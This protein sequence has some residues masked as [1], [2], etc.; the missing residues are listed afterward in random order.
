MRPCAT[1]LRKMNYLRRFST[2]GSSSS[3]APSSLV[4]DHSVFAGRTA[5]GGDDINTRYEPFA[6][7]LD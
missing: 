7:L 1:G 5:L 6:V 3:E 4:E 2:R